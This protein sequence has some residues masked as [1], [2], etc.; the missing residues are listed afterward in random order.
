MKKRIAALLLVLVM[1]VSLPPVTAFAVDDAQDYELRVLTFED[2]DYKGGT[3]F[4]GGNDWSSL[5][6]EPQYGGDML[7]PDGSGT[8]EES[9]AY[10]W[11]DAGNTE[12]KHTLPKS[13]DNYC[14]WGGGHAISHYVSSD[15]AAHG[16]FIDQLTVYSKTASADV[17]TT[18]GGHNG[19]N[20]FAVHFGYKDNS[21]YTDSQ[22]LPSFAFADGVAR[23]VDHMYV[24]NICYALN[25]YL[26]GNGLTAKIGPDD[27]VKLVATGYDAEGNKTGDA[28]IYLCNGPDNIIT[29]WTKFDLSGLGKV[30]KVEFNI[31]GSSDNGYGFSQ[32]AYFAYDDVAVRFEKTVI[33][34][35]SVTLDK[36][37]LTLKPGETGTLTAAVTPENTSDKPVV[38]AS[39]DETV[40]TVENGTVTALKPGTAT[41]T[42]ACGDAQATCTVTVAC[43]HVSGDPVKENITPPTCTA[44]GSHDE[45]IY[46]TICKTEISRKTVTGK[47]TGHDW[48]NGKCKTCSAVCDHKWDDG[49]VTA[50]PTTAKEGEK[51]FT[52]TVCGATKTE[53]I[54]KL[55]N[56]PAPKPGTAAATPV[57]SGKTGDA[58]IALYAGMSLLSLTG[59]AWI[60]G[61][62]RSGK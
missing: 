8:T 28:S 14:Y 1:A 33:P 21:G 44:D 5:I 52:C 49:K 34:A 17:A 38:W 29:D 45:V 4:A 13:W 22:I 53:A 18:G 27:W 24:N 31:T 58:G 19:S 43:Q 60:V 26:N 3:N 36:N 12:L 7:Y 16:S 9:E 30:A 62:K 25:C 51:A 54:A 41:I 57:Q 50:L 48:D 32:P 37:T 42:A 6:D 11:Y 35:E 59:G 55:P 39:S 46:C 61:K 40:A 2:A 23:V 47:A 10:T 20:N 15:F 56:R